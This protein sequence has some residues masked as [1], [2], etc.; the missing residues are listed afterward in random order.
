VWEYIF[1]FQGHG[2]NVKVMVTKQRQHTGLCSP[3]TQF[4]SSF[5]A[6][7]PQFWLVA[8]VQ[9]I[10]WKVMSTTKW[11]YVVSCGV[12]S[13]TYN[14]AYAYF[15]FWLLFAFVVSNTQH[16]R[17]SLIVRWMLLII[18]D[19]R[20]CIE[21]PNKAMCRLVGCWFSM[22]PTL[23]LLHCRDTQQLSWHPSHSRKYWKVVRSWIA[24]SHYNKCFLSVLLWRC[25]I[26]ML[27]MERYIGEFNVL[28][29]VIFYK[30][31][32]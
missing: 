24:N 10:V 21:L 7:V 1:E 17:L 9:L 2:V 18:K 12:W 22:E 27:T 29:F 31:C 30:C 16:W 28:R 25:W 6:G 3:Q 20:H 15:T 14:H 26:L 19:S 5:F 32:Q 8:S 13:V 11:C 23:I 4:N